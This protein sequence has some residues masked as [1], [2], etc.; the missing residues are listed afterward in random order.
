M[1][2]HCFKVDINEEE[3]NNITPM[4]IRDDAHREKKRKMCGE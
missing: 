4:Q 2:D 1:W 3:F